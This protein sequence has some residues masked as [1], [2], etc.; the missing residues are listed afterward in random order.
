MLPTER[1]ARLVCDSARALLDITDTLRKY[2]KGWEHF[3]RNHGNPEEAHRIKARRNSPEHR[4]TVIEGWAKSRPVL[5]AL[6]AAIDT[7]HQ[8]RSV[9]AVDPM[10]AIETDAAFPVYERG[11]AAIVTTNPVRIGN[12]CCLVHRRTGEQIIAELVDTSAERWRVRF[13]VPRRSRWLVRSQW[14]TPVRVRGWTARPSSRELQAGAAIIAAAMG[15]AH[16][17]AVA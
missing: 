13:W 2:S 8:A 6:L 17:Q 14:S 7:Y 3:C 15:N 4:R 1:A 11:H 10:V 16:V 9:T 12:D 5:R